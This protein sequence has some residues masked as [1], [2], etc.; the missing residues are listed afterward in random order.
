MVTS[1]LDFFNFFNRNLT[2][3][4]IFDFAKNTTLSSI[5]ER[6]ECGIFIEIINNV[7]TGT[8][9]LAIIII[10]YILGRNCI[11]C[12]IHTIPDTNR[13]FL[14]QSKNTINETIITINSNINNNNNNNYYNPINDPSKRG[15]IKGG[16]NGKSG[17]NNNNYLNV[18]HENSFTYL[19]VHHMEKQNLQKKRSFYKMGWGMLFYIIFVEIV[20]AFFLFVH[21]FKYDVLLVFQILGLSVIGFSLILSGLILPYWTGLVLITTNTLEYR[22]RYNLLISASKRIAYSNVTM[23]GIGFSRIRW[24]LTDGRIIEMD[25]LK[26]KAY[27]IEGLGEKS[28]LLNAAEKIWNHEIKKNR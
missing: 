25:T 18:E 14:T 13:M 12:I 7:L 9:F 17:E 16:G 20:V 28:L 23:L 11:K 22:K 3:D 26:I 5:C 10:T 19:Q 8:F 27:D 2:I 21:I 24:G 1:M 15:K 4:S 6:G